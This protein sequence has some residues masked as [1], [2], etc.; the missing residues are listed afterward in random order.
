MLISADSEEIAY[1][2]TKNII[3]K[4]RGM[5][6]TDRTN[7]VYLDAMKSPVARVKNKFRY[8][9]LMRVINWQKIRKQIYELCDNEKD[10][11]ISLFV[12]INP[13]NLS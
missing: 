11:K 8:Q 4:V 7:F 6:E 5:R 2:K 1:E 9:V 10:A 13:Q 12:E 3:Q